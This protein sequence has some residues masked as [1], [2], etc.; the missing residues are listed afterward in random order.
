MDAQTTA[1]RDERLPRYTSYP[2]APHFT[3][4]VDGGQFGRWLGDLAPGTK[5]SL[6]LHVPFCRAMCWYCGC[7][8]TVARRD[9]PIGDYLA[10]LRREIETVADH[11]RAPLDVRHIHFGGG[12]PTILAPDDFVD[13]VAL[14]RRRFALRPDAEIAVEIDPRHL[15][16]AMIDALRAAGV[17]RAS[18]G[19][20]SFDPSV[21]AAI[22]RIQS[23]EQT[24]TVVEGLRRA[25]IAAVNLDLIYGLP[26]Q[27]V[28]SCIETVE[29]CLDLAPDRFS[30][31]GY[32]HVPDFKKHQSRIATADLPDG[33]ARHEQAE[34]MAQRLVA[35]GYVR[36]G[37]DHF[38]RPADEMARALG[39]GRLRRNFQGYTTD[40]CEALLGFGASA[41]GRL[42]QGYVQNE[43]VIGRYGERVR[44]GALPTAKGYCLSADDRL[45]AEL[46]ERLMCD[47]SV[48]I[49]AV[50]ARHG[51]DPRTL[52]PSLSRLD[53]LSQEGVIA[54]DGARLLLPEQSRL[55]V[56]KV[57]SLFDAHIDQPARRYSRAV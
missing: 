15:T 29:L 27:T 41:I 14:L 12:T 35:A 4:D 39:S 24:A 55:L 32:A 21:Q 1:Y 11:L 54:F 44:D 25:G 45:R 34:A 18:L 10:V 43:V 23:V 30:I 47:L 57:A 52:A 16:V 7:H 9:G 40:G 8:T 6:Y 26:R 20:Q 13:L 37:L 48:D 36:I 51:A 46:I 33:Q 28:E 50:C 5:G 2:T 31:F 42:P 56:R 49:D 38:A 19:V 3:D 17:N 53:L 22:N